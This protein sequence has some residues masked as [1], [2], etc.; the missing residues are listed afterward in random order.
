MPFGRPDAL[1]L[2]LLIPV[3]GLLLA[4]TRL[5]RRRLLGRFGREDLVARL[6]E[7]PGAGRWAARLLLI[8][9]ASTFLVL[10]LARPRW[11][12]KVEEVRRRG[13]DVLVAVDVSDSMLATDVQPSRL[14]R[15]RGLVSTLLDRLAGDRVGLIAF[16]GEATTL[17]PLTLDYAAARVFLDVLDGSLVPLPGTDLAAAIRR[18]SETFGRR[19]RRYKILILLTDGE[20]HGREALDAA[21]EA[22]SEGVVIYTVGLGTGAGSPIPLREASGAIRGY[23]QD[24]SG[25]I[26]TSRLDPVKL[27]EIA[28]AADGRYLPSTP[29][30]REIQEIED[31]IA[32]M[33][34]RQVGTRLTI[35]Y[36]ERYQIP[37]ALA[38]AALFLEAGI[39]ERLFPRREEVSG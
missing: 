3:L 13:V 23:K 35:T 24:R 22:A 9:L 5:R 38:L 11:G 26:V 16:A 39:G 19:E 31:R 10:T 32:R 34:R 4:W 2:L 1:W 17:C 36:E 37:L 21:R 6:V 33:E 27:A 25:R 12:R 7:A 28:E 30:G 29:E 15:A 8:L 18:A 14:A 20:D